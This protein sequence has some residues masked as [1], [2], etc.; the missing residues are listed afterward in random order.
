MYRAG[1]SARANTSVRESALYWLGVSRRD[2]A[3]SKARMDE[4]RDIRMSVQVEPQETRPDIKQQRMLREEIAELDSAIAYEIGLQAAID[5]DIARTQ[6]MLASGDP[7]V[8]GMQ[9]NW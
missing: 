4:Y 6:R 1:A 2:K 9:M 3:R 8:E 7:W 5:Q